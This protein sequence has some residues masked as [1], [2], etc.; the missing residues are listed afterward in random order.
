ME[1]SSVFYVYY[2]TNI[3]Y[4][5]F[6]HSFSPPSLLFSFY[7]RFTLIKIHTEYDVQDTRVTRTGKIVFCLPLG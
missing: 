3:Y 1:R 2:M 6:I 5:I 4:K 7:I